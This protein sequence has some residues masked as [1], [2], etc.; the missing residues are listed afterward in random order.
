M[1]TAFASK[2]E[3]VRR[4]MTLQRTLV[5]LVFCRYSQYLRRLGHGK[6]RLTYR[7]RLNLDPTWVE[8]ENV[9]WYIGKQYLH[10]NC[11]SCNWAQFRCKTV[12][13]VI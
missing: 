13:L 5:T 10:A 12:S 3:A 2:G 4:N 7:H 9:V 11:E 8:D 1:I 6:K